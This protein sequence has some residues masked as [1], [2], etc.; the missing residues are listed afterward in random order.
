M[1]DMIREN[2]EGGGY[3][4]RDMLLKIDRSWYEGSLDATERDAL[5]AYARERAVPEDSYA[6]QQARLT[7][8]E[9]ALR[10]LETRVAALEEAGGSGSA[11][12]AEVAEW[13]QPT[14]AHDAYMV[15]DR[16]VF[17]GK[18]YECRIDGCV[19]SP[20]DYPAGWKEASE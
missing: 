14:G 1:Y 2:I 5:K 18:T 12:E 17:G 3:D 8:L 13:K 4:L 10:A 9:V 6:S 15:G 7:A 20:T 19:W 11:G 16:V